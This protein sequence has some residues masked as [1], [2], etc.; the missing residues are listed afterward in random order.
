MEPFTHT[1]PSENN[2][3]D[4][5]IDGTSARSPKRG[6]TPRFLAF[7]IAVMLVALFAGYEWL[8]GNIKYVEVTREDLGEARPIKP[9]S[10]A[11]NILV[12]GSDER[13]GVGHGDPAGQRTDIIMLVHLSLTRNEVA[14]I[15]FPRDSMVQLPACRS[16]DGLPGQQRRHGMINASFNFGGMACTWKTVESLTGIH[17]DHF[18]KFDFTG[19]K[20]MVDAMGGVRLCID[21]PIRDKYVQLD[22]SQGLQSLRGEQALGYV[23][24]RH[25]L[26]DG[27]DIGR[28]KRQQEFFAA[29]LKQATSGE[30]LFNPVRLFLVLAATTKSMTA[31]TDLTPRVLMSVALAVRKLS[32]GEIQFVTVPWRYSKTFPGRVEWLTGPAKNLFRLTATDRALARPD[33]KKIQVPATSIATTMAAVPCSPALPSKDPGPVAAIELVGSTSQSGRTAMRPVGNRNKPKTDER[34]P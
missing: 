13:D 16:R 7:L 15:S 23:R 32:S 19:F 6:W 18:L 11:L 2:V 17:I 8:F 9:P 29:M 27:T 1:S 3:G 12:V 14:V 34:R 30:T 31:D 24:V 21:A 28:I 22:L 26:G 33:A 4:G 20:D 10:T 25:N 5:S